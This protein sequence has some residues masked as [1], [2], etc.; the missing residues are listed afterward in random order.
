LN[1]LATYLRELRDIRSSGATEFLK[2][3][4]LYAAPLTNPADVAWF[5]GPT[6]RLPSAA[7]LAP[8]A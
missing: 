4:M 6:N 2:R 1:P 7:A 5:L 8:S 3:V